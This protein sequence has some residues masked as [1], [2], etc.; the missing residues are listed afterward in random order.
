[1]VSHIKKYIPIEEY[2]DCDSIKPVN[3]PQEQ[4][5]N[6]TTYYGPF[7][8]IVD[9]STS[10]NREEQWALIFTNNNTNDKSSN[11]MPSNLLLKGLGISDLAKQV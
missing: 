1:M 6:V 7:A 3:E 4:I 8:P 2:W 10:I 5:S 11:S 9:N